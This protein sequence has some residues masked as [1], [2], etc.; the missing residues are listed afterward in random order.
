MQVRSEII[1]TKVKDAFII[2]AQTGKAVILRIWD[3]T[4]CLQARDIWKEV[5]IKFSILTER[6]KIKILEVADIRGLY[7]T[8]LNVF[9]KK[10]NNSR[11][12]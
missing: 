7:H 6:T 5:T 4:S 10:C 3:S 1:A 2:Y 12:L 11:L 9:S 8:L